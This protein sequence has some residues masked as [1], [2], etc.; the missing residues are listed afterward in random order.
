ML[1]PKTAKWSP[2]LPPSLEIQNKTVIV[3]T[4]IF[5]KVC[6]V[7]YVLQFVDFTRNLTQQSLFVHICYQKSSI[8]I[9]EGEWCFHQGFFYS[10]TWKIS[11]SLRKKLRRKKNYLWWTTRRNSYKP[12]NLSILQTVRIRSTFK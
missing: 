11:Y 8:L 12:F 3:T 4:L 2:F 9:L 6:N 7:Q 10:I 1:F 5:F